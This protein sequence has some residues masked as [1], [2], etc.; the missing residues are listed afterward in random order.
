MATTTQSPLYPFF[1]DFWV[2]N[3]ACTQDRLDKAVTKGYITAD[4]E[5][6]TILATPRQV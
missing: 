5:E 2:N 1:L 4:S 3:S 6:T